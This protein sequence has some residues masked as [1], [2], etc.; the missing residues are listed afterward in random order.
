MIS[1]VQKSEWSLFIL[2]EFSSFIFDQNTPVELCRSMSARFL[3]TNGAHQ[4]EILSSF[5]FSL[6]MDD[7]S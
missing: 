6:Y 3:L 1:A 7:G 5:F 2:L 4:T